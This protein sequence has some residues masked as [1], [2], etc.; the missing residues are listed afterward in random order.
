MKTSQQILKT[1]RKKGWSD[2]R[3]GKLAGV[4]E[5]TIRRVRVDET[6]PP[7]ELSWRAG[8]R[9]YDAVILRGQFP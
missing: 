5:E 1:A 8:W 2:K 9:I 3:L 7:R 4:S 6:T